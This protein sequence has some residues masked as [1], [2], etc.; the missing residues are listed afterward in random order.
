MIFCSSGQF[1]QCQPFLNLEVVNWHS[2]VDNKWV[3]DFADPLFFF[4]ISLAYNE[5]SIHF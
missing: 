1:C 5:A 4:A 3:T 2:A